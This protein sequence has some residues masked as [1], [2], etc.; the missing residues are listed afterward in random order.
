MNFRLLI[1][2]NT[3]VSLHYFIYLMTEM[4]FN[5]SSQNWG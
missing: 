3:F 5:F 2:V 1:V 4:S